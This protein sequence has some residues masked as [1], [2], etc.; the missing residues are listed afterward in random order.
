MGLGKYH[1]LKKEYK[2]AE[3]EFLRSLEW[4]KKAGKPDFLISDHTGLGLAYE[5]KGGYVKAKGHFMEAIDII[6]AQWKT[7][8]PVAKK[9]FLSGQTGVGF[10]R[11]EPYEG[12]VRVLYKEKGKGYERES[13]SVAEEV[14][15]RL[16]LEMLATRQ[17]KGLKGPDDTVLRKDREFQE[18]LI[19]LRKRIEVMEGMKD[20]GIHKR[21]E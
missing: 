19:S 1:L 6:E 20:R 10:T 3:R 8:S 13:L 15:S 9:D 17:A 21:L 14:R 5:G 18:A 4:T 11:I 7:L 12:L 2:D 16:F